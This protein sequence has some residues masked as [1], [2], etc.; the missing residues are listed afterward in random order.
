MEELQRKYDF[1]YIRQSG[2]LTATEHHNTCLQLATTR[3]VWL[4]HDD[5][6][7]CPGVFEGVEACLKDSEDAG[8]VV[9]GV[10]DIT[11]AGEVTRQWVPTDNGQLKGDAGLLELGWNW[12][13]RAP[14]QIFGDVRALRSGDFGRLPGTRPIFPLHARWPI[15]MGASFI[16]KLLADGAQEA[17][18][19]R[20]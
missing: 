14:C 4:L 2:K 19:H 10:E 13:A 3:W 15:P 17:I 16:R 18:K 9:G 8:I 12:R 1:S 7:L 6:E 5:D 20:T 11:H